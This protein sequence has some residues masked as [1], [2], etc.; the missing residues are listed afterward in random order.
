MSTRTAR[1]SRRR[2]TLVRR[3]VRGAGIA[4]SVLAKAL[5]LVGAAMVILTGWRMRDFTVDAPAATAMLPLTLSRP[6]AQAFRGAYANLYGVDML[7]E[8]PGGAADLALELQDEAGTLLRASGA[9]LQ[10]PGRQWASFRFPD[11]PAA[12][13][14]RYVLWMRAPDSAYRDGL[15]VWQSEQPRPGHGRLLVEGQASEAALVYRP[16]YRP[17]VTEILTVYAARLAEGHGGALGLPTLYGGLIFAYLF[18]LAA[19]AVLIVRFAFKYIR[20][21]RVAPDEQAAQPE[22]DPLEL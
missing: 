11:V 7:V 12:R 10:E 22:G 18:V 14:Q 13:G 20:A 4:R 6:I 9:R 5:L 8:H 17:S 19:L 3:I 2:G 15:A 1:P 16:H 21:A